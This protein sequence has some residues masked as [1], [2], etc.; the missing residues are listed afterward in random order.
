MANNFRKEWSE[1]LHLTAEF[2]SEIEAYVQWKMSHPQESTTQFTTVRCNLLSDSQIAWTTVE[3]YIWLYLNKTNLSTT[4]RIQY[5]VSF[6]FPAASLL[7]KMEW[8]K[9]NTGKLLIMLNIMHI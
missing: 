1:K 2:I 4:E 6:G 3:L 9:S 8:L 7:A 5:L